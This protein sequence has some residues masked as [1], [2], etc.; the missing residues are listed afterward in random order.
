MISLK[1][2]SPPAARYVAERAWSVIEA[3]SEGVSKLME[4]PFIKLACHCRY[5][6]VSRITV[7]RLE[8]WLE[9]NRLWFRSGMMRNSSQIMW[10][11]VP[12]V[13]AWDRL[14]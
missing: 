10:N 13:A 11:G 2:L 14:N 6:G 8:D 4:N 1:G 5:E 9:L 12:I 3:E 7:K